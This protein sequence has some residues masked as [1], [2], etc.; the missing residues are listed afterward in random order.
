[1]AHSPLEACPVRQ[2]GPE[3][4]RS[5]HCRGVRS[6]D[7]TAQ[8]RAGRVCRVQL[9]GVGAFEHAESDA[10]RDSFQHGG[11]RGGEEDARGVGSEGGQVLHP[12][13][14]ATASARCL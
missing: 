9:L 14:S 3:H 2:R 13:R 1:M 8:R 5:R 10:A 4:G 12:R 7:R 11:T 6:R